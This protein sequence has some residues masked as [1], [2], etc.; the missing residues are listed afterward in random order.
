MQATHSV[1]AAERCLTPRSSGAPTAGHQGPAWGTRYIFPVRALASCRWRPLSSN[2][3]HP[4]NAAS[5]GQQ[6]VRLSAGMEQPQGGNA[7]GRAGVIE[8]HQ[9]L[10][11]INRAPST[12]PEPE[13]RRSRVIQIERSGRCGREVSDVSTRRESARAWKPREEQR[14][15]SAQHA[16]SKTSAQS[17]NTVALI[18]RRGAP[19]KVRSG[20]RRRGVP[21]LL[22]S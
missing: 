5:L 16:V 19:C 10:P 18:A 9:P 22:L 14:S 12:F 11:A 20:R 17:G 4:R 21:R 13:A 15:K 7:A 1:A 8:S 6:E 2:V 3:R